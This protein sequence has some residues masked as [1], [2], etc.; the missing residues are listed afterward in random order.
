MLLIN[1]DARTIPLADRSVHLVVCS[2]P[3]FGLRKYEAGDS[4]IGLE[5][6]PEEFIEAIVIAGRE[7]WRVLRDDGC[8]WLNL[9]DSYAG[10]GKGGQ[11]ESKRSDGWQPTY[12]NHGNTPIGYKPK[13]KLLIPHRVAMALQAD[14]WWVTQDMPW[15]K[16]NPM[17]ESA[18]MRPT[19]AHEYVFLLAKGQ[20]K[21]S[22]VKF[23]DIPDECVHFQNNF[24]FEPTKAPLSFAPFAIDNSAV[25]QICVCLATAIFYFSQLQYNFSLPP[26]YSEVWKKCPDG[27]DSSFVRGIPIE[28]RPSVFSARFLASDMTAKEFMQEINSLTVTLPNGN[29]FLIGG[30]SPKFF[31]SPPIN[32]DRNGTI[33]INY[34]SQISKIDFIHDQIIIQNPE[35]CKYFF[36]MEA[37]RRGFTEN[38][39]G[40]L[41]SGPGNTCYGLDGVCKPG[42]KLKESSNLG[43]KPNPAGRS[44]RTSDFWYDSLDELID[45]HETQA[46]YLREIKRGGL[47]LSEDGTPECFMVNT[48]A[49]SG[50]HYACFPEKLVRPM[51]QA[52]TSEMGVCPKCGAGWVRVVEVGGGMIGKSWFKGDDRLIEGNRAY[53]EAKGGHGYYRR[54]IGWRPACNCYDDEYSRDFRQARSARKRR[55]RRMSGDWWRRVKLIAVPFDWETVPAIVLD[56]FVGSGT[57]VLVAKQLGRRGIGLD[58]SFSYLRD[59]A[60]ERTGLKAL[61]E[62]ERGASAAGELDGLPLFA[63]TGY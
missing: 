19:T 8:W 56:P 33:T 15:I 40:W 43:G 12:A 60:R 42:D 35:K 17:P 50:A 39:I 34:A 57:T 13:D 16:R 63:K 29:E 28:H 58:L 38:S 11:S 36:D 52:G 49:Y 47:M 18:K 24:R 27:T 14:G 9:G 61:Q 21:T 55:Q 41:K 46:R 26:F 37:V 53:N 22:I 54:S 32:A 3:Y 59:Q 51:I 7:I 10:S 31:C 4:Q 45:Y 23:S 44:L 30:I 5:P 25:I 2:P 20:W 6:T 48:Q 1:A 62:W